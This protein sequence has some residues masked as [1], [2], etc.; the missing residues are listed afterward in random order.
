MKI[1]DDSLGNGRVARVTT[2][3]AVPKKKAS[4]NPL[5]RRRRWWII[6]GSILALLVIPGVLNLVNSYSAYA[7]P[8][9]AAMILAAQE[10]LP[11]GILIPA[12]L[13]KGFDREGVEMKIY[14][15]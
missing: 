10:G 11:F 15:G 13:P 9:E 3:P 6:S 8:P 1:N 7:D 4:K 12:F 14:K 5:W 2:K